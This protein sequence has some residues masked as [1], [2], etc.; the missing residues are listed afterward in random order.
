MIIF[1]AIQDNMRGPEW[2][3]NELKVSSLQGS[4]ETAKQNLF[5][6]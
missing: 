4:K 6:I 5:S 1:K 2:Y 3:C